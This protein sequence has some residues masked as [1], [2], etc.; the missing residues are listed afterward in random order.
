MTL[1]KKKSEGQGGGKKKWKT[2]QNK[3]LQQ[4]EARAT[5]NTK[6]KTQNNTVRRKIR[7]KIHNNTMQEEKRKTQS[8]FYSQIFN[9]IV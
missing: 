8:P 5:Q 2:T 6:S 7:E 1:N 4:H 3:S 9:F